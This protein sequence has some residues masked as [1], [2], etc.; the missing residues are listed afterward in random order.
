MN[1]SVSIQQVKLRC[2]TSDPSTVWQIRLFRPAKPNWML[3]LDTTARPPGE[4]AMDVTWGTVSGDPLDTFTCVSLRRMLDAAIDV[5]MWK[6]GVGSPRKAR[7]ASASV[8][9]DGEEAPAAVGVVAAKESERAEFKPEIRARVGSNGSNPP[10]VGTSSTP[11]GRRDALAIECGFGKAREEEIIDDEDHEC[12]IPF[13]LQHTKFI[14]DRWE[15][16]KLALLKAYEL[17]RY[18]LKIE[19]EDFVGQLI[20]KLCWHWM[21]TKLPHQSISHEERQKERGIPPRIRAQIRERELDKKIREKID[22]NVDD[23]GGGEGDAENLEGG[24]NYN[25]NAAPAKPGPPQVK[26]LKPTSVQPLVAPGTGFPGSAKNKAPGQDNQAEPTKKPTGGVVDKRSVPPKQR[27]ALVLRNIQPTSKKKV[28]PMAREYQKEFLTRETL[29]VS[30]HRP[31]TAKPIVFDEPLSPTRKIKREVGF[32][33][34]ESTS[35]AGAVGRATAG[36]G[37]SSS[38]VSPGTAS[39]LKQNSTATLGGR[40]TTAANRRTMRE[41]AA[42]QQSSGWKLP[43]S[44]ENRQVSVNL[45]NEQRREAEMV[46]VGQ[47]EVA[48]KEE[49]LSKLRQGCIQ[50]RLDLAKMQPVKIGTSSFFKDGIGDKAKEVLPQQEQGN[51]T[52]SNTTNNSSSVIPGAARTNLRG[53]R[54]GVTSIM[55]RYSDS[56]IDDLD[57]PGESIGTTAPSGP[58]SSRSNSKSAKDIQ[59]PELLPRPPE[60]LDGSGLQPAPRENRWSSEENIPVLYS[61]DYANKDEK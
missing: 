54:E 32:A 46:E 61:R 55:A 21:E 43:E 58:A 40:G 11:A 2:Y 14:M 49:L 15:L 29:R 12:G 56:P 47:R 33:P 41:R 38:A 57:Q 5:E 45:K 60:A 7:R 3:K 4:A 19:S 34:F 27:P 42:V 6:T 23:E 51:A 18:V 10:V 48:K 13:S 24:N 52:A 53:S 31:S 35:S 17:T 36:G 8:D 37:G 26:R 44:A 25:N 59:P 9:Y 1:A 20:V 22:E 39:T 30:G 16:H 28:R 50:M